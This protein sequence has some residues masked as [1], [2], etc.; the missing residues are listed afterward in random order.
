MNEEQSEA[1]SADLTKVIV[2]KLKHAGLD[3]NEAFGILSLAVLN[4]LLT[5]AMEDAVEDNRTTEDQ[6]NLFCLLVEEF[7]EN[8]LRISNTVAASEGSEIYTID[9]S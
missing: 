2:G 6:M 8:L 7:K 3:H 9:L 1:I 5:V 4:I